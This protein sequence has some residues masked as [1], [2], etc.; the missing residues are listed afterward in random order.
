MAIKLTTTK[1]ATLFAKILVYG[2]A[3]VGKTRLIKTA[4]NPIIISAEGGMLSLR[5]FN[6]PLIEINGIEDLY[7]A[8][9]YVTSKKAVDFETVC[10]DSISDIAEVLLADFKQ[11]HKDPRKAYG[12]MADECA[13]FIRKFRDIKNKHVYVT[14]KLRRIQQEEGGELYYPSMPGTQMVQNIPYF[15]DEVLALRIIEDEEDGKTK[16]LLQC[17]PDSQYDAKDR[18]GC[19]EMFERP[20]LKTIINKIIT[21][22]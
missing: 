10:L 5:K 20:N 13:K 16:R 17:Q 21:E 9:E 19:L 4:P 14:A 22:E 18:S 2:R 3:G 7:E 1:K 12:D 8:Y 6:L 11:K 15:F